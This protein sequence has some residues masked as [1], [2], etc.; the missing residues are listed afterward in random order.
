MTVIGEEK[1][2]KGGRVSVTLRVYSPL[3]FKKKK[4]KITHFLLMMPRGVTRCKKALFHE[5]SQMAE[6]GCGISRVRKKKKGFKIV[7]QNGAVAPRGRSNL[8]LWH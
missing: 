5:L 7:A 6:G 2:K 1:R 4:K 8:A 3:V